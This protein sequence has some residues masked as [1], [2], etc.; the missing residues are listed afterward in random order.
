MSKKLTKIQVIDE[1]VEFYGANPKKRRSM[2]SDGDCAYKGT[3]G[4]MCAIA[5]YTKPDSRV[6]LHENLEIS[7]Y[8][9]KFIVTDGNHLKKSVA[10]IKS[11]EFWDGVQDLH[12]REIHWGDTELTIYGK[13]FV[14]RLKH[15]CK[16]GRYEN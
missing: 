12:D 16:S 13:Q 8:I 2:A 15:N 3:C 7:S 14:K 1:I 5:R 11:L 9:N 10:H 4:R 6:E